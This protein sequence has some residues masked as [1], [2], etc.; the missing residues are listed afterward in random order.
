MEEPEKSWKKAYHVFAVFLRLYVDSIVLGPQLPWFS[1]EGNRRSMLFWRSLLRIFLRK[2][3]NFFLRAAGDSRNCKFC[4]QKSLTVLRIN[5]R[6]TALKNNITFFMEISWRP[7]CQYVA[8]QFVLICVYPSKTLC[9]R[10]NPW[11]NLLKSQKK[12]THCDTQLSLHRKNLLTVTVSRIE[13]LIIRY[14][15]RLPDKLKHTWV[16]TSKRQGG[17]MIFTSFDR[18]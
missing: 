7:H 10:C 6:G 4:I 17:G 8:A 3:S 13:D 12:F 2:K 18:L 15:H 5:Q 1:R 9:P 16:F 14:L 11:L